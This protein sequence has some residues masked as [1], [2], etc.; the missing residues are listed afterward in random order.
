M[1]RTLL[2]AVCTAGLC[3]AAIAQAVQPSRHDAPHAQ[4][5]YRQTSFDEFS[6]D[7]MYR[8]AGDEHLASL[9]PS[10]FL[11]GLP[12]DT[13]SAVSG[14]PIDFTEHYRGYQYDAERNAQRPH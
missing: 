4:S 6:T 11:N 9:Q 8:N 12:E 2:F 13:D 10:R 5:E 3:A 7:R 14:H 1:W